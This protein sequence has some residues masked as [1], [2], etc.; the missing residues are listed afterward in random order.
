MNLFH[1]YN[2]NQVVLIQIDRHHDVDIKFVQ[3]T[4]YITLS[5]LIAI[6]LL[7]LLL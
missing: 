5:R 2:E 3:T 6:L 7:Q 4:V 1:R